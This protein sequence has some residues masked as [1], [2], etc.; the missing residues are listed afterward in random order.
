M[1][2]I[3]CTLVLSITIA[4]STWATDPGVTDSQL[5]FGSVLAL[6]GKAKGLGL[7]MQKGLNAA[8]EEQTVKGKNIIIKYLNDFYEPRKSRNAT[9]T[10]IDQGIFLMIGNVGTPTAKVTLPLLAKANIPAVGF[11]TGA[12]ILRPAPGPVVNFRAS[13]IQETAAVINQ[14][15]ANGLK[16]NEVCAYVQNDAYGMAGLVGI[17][18]AL[19]EHNADTDVLTLYDKIIKMEGVIPARNGIGPIGVYQRNTNKVRPGYQSLVDWEQKTG[20]NCKLVV[21]VGA[22]GNIAHFVRVAN[23]VN[24]EK[25]IIS[26]VS[27]TGADNYKADLTKYKATE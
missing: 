17:R 14:G 16:P 9:I 13:Y 8:L 1:R 22:Y 10:L 11:F 15:I 27:F 18:Q 24:K 5:I 26:A 4:N 19:A 2:L 7:G 20:K 12:G 3:H 25:W 21:T 6:K 23:V